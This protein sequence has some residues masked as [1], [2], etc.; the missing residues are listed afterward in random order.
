MAPGVAREHERDASRMPA[1]AE[2]RRRRRLRYHRRVTPGFPDFFSA[3]ADAYARY[4][5]LYP[6]ELL[7]RIAALAPDR[8]CCWDVATGTGQA[9]RA[10]AEHFER[11]IATDASARQISHARRHPR[12]DYRVEVAERSS[13]ADGSVD[14]ITIA[15]GLHWLALDAFYDEVRRVA[16]PGAVIA[17]WSYGARFGF[18]GELDDV[19]AEHVERVLGPYWPEGHRHI[20][21]GYRTLEF[22]FAEI[23]MPPASL[24]L[25]CALDDILGF[26]GTWSASALFRAD[27]GRDPATELRAPL[28]AAWGAEPVRTVHIPLFFRVGRI[29]PPGVAAAPL[30]TSA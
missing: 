7:A 13:L 15:A 11:V 23:A 28:A 27:L 9:A 22:P 2:P 14:L 12:I 24:T 10:L 4:R 29:D 21:S 1:S 17:A 8:R 3:G 30:A 19:V 16:R 26:I 6:P 20:R 25:S 18:G 5:P